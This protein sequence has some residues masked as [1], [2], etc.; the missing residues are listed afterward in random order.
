MTQD[1]RMGVKKH[2]PSSIEKA[3]IRHIFPYLNDKRVLGFYIMHSMEWCSHGQYYEVLIGTGKEQEYFRIWIFARAFLVISMEGSVL[4]KIN[5]SCCEKTKL[6]SDASKMV[7]F[8]KCKMGI[9]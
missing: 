1:K 7:D 3:R 6:C 9:K 4:M 2:F 8:L 5:N